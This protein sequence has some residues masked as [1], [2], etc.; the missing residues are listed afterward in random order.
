MT[1][2][3]KKLIWVLLLAVISQNL[4]SQESEE[5]I[6]NKVYYVTTINQVMKDRS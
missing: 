4:F 3:I 1:L 5:I 2:K 6:I